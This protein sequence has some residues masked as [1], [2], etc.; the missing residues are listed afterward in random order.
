MSLHKFV[1]LPLVSAPF[2]AVFFQIFLSPKNRFI[3]RSTDY[4]GDVPR[5]GTP[6]FGLAYK[7]RVIFTMAISEET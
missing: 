5:L 7:L 6:F 3:P 4:Q 1:H 2:G